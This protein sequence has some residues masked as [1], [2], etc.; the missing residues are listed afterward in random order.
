MKP[1][2]P[3]IFIL[4]VLIEAVKGAVQYPDCLNGLL[5]SNLV[6]DTTAPPSSRAA[7]LV[8]SLT[9]A[10][11][12]A[13]LTNNSPGIPRFGLSPYQWWNEDLHVVAHNRGITWA[14]NRPFSAETQFPQ[15]IT[16]LAAF[17]DELIEKIGETIGT[18]VRAFANV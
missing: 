12:L 3:N 14:Q 7:A 8:S 17:D 16:R 2:L 13:N 11:K 6:C 5:E 10:E 9:N 18:E 4:S 1:F 15:A